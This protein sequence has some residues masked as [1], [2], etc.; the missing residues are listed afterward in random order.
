[1]NASRLAAF[2][3]DVDSAAVLAARYEFGALVAVIDRGIAG[4]P[5]YALTQRETEKAM[6]QYAAHEKSATGAR[7]RR[8]RGKPGREKKGD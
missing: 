3:F 6:A 7:T 4:A 8:T 1:M 2:V 5:K